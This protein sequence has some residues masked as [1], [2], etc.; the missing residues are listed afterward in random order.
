MGATG[1]GDPAVPPH[2]PD[3]SA[4]TASCHS[5]PS[6]TSSSQF[7][8]NNLKFI[9]NVHSK[10]KHFQTIH[11]K[12]SE[13]KI[14]KSL[15][16]TANIK[17]FFSLLAVVTCGTIKIFELLKSSA[18]WRLTLKYDFCSSNH[19]W[20]LQ[21][22]NSGLRQ[23][24]SIY[25]YVLFIFHNIFNIQF[26]HLIFILSRFIYMFYPSQLKFLNPDKWGQ[27]LF[28]K[29]WWMMKRVNSKHVSLSMM[30]HIMKGNYGIPFQLLLTTWTFDGQNVVFFQ[31][32][33]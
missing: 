33:Q 4:W 9:S 8:N 11:A 1:P 12:L 14:V 2:P 7:W 18:L 10:H 28:K 20:S 27:G 5:Q 23:W 24:W 6:Y 26:S 15:E 3:W 32:I 25:M 22:Q 16:I 29:F 17:D 31:N 13:H 21:T 19:N 30:I